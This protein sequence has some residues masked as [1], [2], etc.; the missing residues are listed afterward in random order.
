MLRLNPI[1]QSNIIA[2]WHGMDLTMDRKDDVVITSICDLEIQTLKH[3]NGAM[4]KWNDA[5]EIRKT[6]WRKMN[7]RNDAMENEM[8]EMET[9]RLYNQKNVSQLKIGIVACRVLK[10][11]LDI[12]ALQ[13]SKS[14][15]GRIRRPFGHQPSGESKTLS[16]TDFRNQNPKSHAAIRT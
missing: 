16:R 7:F 4:E 10:R 3:Q 8:M 12:D 15:G 11:S 5:Y 9:D 14:A 2:S 1:I 6:F 13:A